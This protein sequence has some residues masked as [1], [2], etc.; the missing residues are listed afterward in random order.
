MSAALEWVLPVV[1]VLLTFVAVAVV[2]IAGFIAYR[3]TGAHRVMTDKEWRQYMEG[4]TPR[5]PPR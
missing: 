4:L 5:I 3:L 1:I 2:L